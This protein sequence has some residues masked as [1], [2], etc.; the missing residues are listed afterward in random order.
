MQEIFIIRVRINGKV[1]AKIAPR[2]IESLDATKEAGKGD[3]E[4]P[5][6]K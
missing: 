1:K 6:R 2:L 4:V 3:Y 5:L